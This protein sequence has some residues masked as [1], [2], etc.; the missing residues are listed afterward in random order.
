MPGFFLVCLGKYLTILSVADSKIAVEVVFNV[1]HRLKMN[2]FD[3]IQSPWTAM[4][5]SY[6]SACLSLTITPSLLFMF[7]THIISLSL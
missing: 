2:I 3:T 7:A 1:C 5:L 4:H 6:Q